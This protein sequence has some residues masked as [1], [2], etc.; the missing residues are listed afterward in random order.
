MRGRSGHDHSHTGQ[1]WH[2][3]NGCLGN[4]HCVPGGLLRLQEPSLLAH[5]GAIMVLLAGGVCRKKHPGNVLCGSQSSSPTVS[6]CPHQD[7][8]P[9]RPTSPQVCN[10]QP[11]GSPQSSCLLSGSGLHQSLP[12]LYSPTHQIIKKRKKKKNWTS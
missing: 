3:P 2:L 4:G 12:Y 11:S 5:S 7:P 10:Q 8:G 1:W 6:F 9:D